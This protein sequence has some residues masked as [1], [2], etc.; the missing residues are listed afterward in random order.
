MGRIQ[1]IDHESGSPISAIIIPCAGK[2]KVKPEPRATALILP[3]ASQR[4]LETA[5]IKL[6]CELRPIA[7][8]SRLYGGRSF[9]LGRDAADRFRAR[10]YVVS[11]GLGFVPGERPV[12]AYGLTVSRRGP[13]SVAARALGGFDPA[14]WW[15]AVASG[16]YSTSVDK[17]LADSGAG[18]V[19]VAFTKPY[20]EMFGAALAGALGGATERV[21]LF[22]RGLSGHVP[23]ALERLVMPYDDRLD[24]LLPGTRTDFSVR[25]LSHFANN[26]AANVGTYAEHHEAVSAA[27]ARVA[28]PPR[29]ERPRLPDDAIIALIQEH[30]K[31]T[32]GIGRTLRRL[33][34]QDA[35]ACEQ[36]RF[37]RLYRIAAGQEARS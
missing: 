30:L 17:S 28:R 4:E 20:A 24:V 11:A 27:M 12:P 32:S 16:P 15:R 8:A 3:R 13:D 10:L 33:R 29:A 37:T 1:Q 19:L 6:L 9:G 35:I 18:L 31:T 7:E 25:A 2:K 26:Y 22:G 5:W 14:A 34:D 36:A 21:R 23:A